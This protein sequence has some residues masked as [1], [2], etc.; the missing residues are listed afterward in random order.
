M[1]LHMMRHSEGEQV[2]DELANISRGDDLDLSGQASWRAQSLASMAHE[3]WRL[4][5]EQ[6]RGFSGW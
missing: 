6:Q 5:P 1:G 4:D 2:K 3:R